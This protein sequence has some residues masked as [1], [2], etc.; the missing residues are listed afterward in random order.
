MSSFRLPL[1]GHDNKYKLAV[2]PNGL[3]ALFIHSP[4]AEHFCISIAVRAGSLLDPPYL[5]GLAHLCEHM[6]FTG[7]KEYPKTG[8]FQSAVFEAG[9]DANAFTTGL[10]TN[11]FMEVPNESREKYDLVDQ[12][13]SFFRKPLFKKDAL[14]LEI[15]AIEEEHTLYSSSEQKILYHAMKLLCNKQHSFSRFFTGN[16]HTLQT[17]TG[18]SD[19]QIIGELSDF[20]HQNYILSNINIIIKSSDPIEIMEKKVNFDFISRPKRQKDNTNNSAF[21]GQSG[22]NCVFVSSNTHC[23]IRLFIPINF[24]TSKSKLDLYIRIWTILLGDEAPGTAGKYLIKTSSLASNITCQCQ[25]VDHDEKLLIVDIKPTPSGYSKLKVIVRVIV[26]YINFI[27]NQNPSKL[28]EYLSE[29][30]LQEATT[31]KFKEFCD[32]TTDEVCGLAETLSLKYNHI[33]TKNLIRGYDDW[34]DIMPGTD[35]ISRTENF[36]LYSKNFLKLDDLKVVLVGKIIPELDAVSVG[37]CKT[38]THTDF[39]FEYEILNVQ[40]KTFLHPLEVT[41]RQVA[42]TELSINSDSNQAEPLSKSFSMQPSLLSDQT[43]IEFWHNSSTNSDYKDRISVHI[44]FPH[45]DRTTESAVMFDIL[46]NHLGNSLRHDLYV[47]EGF[48]V[49]WS[50]C[51][52]LNRENSLTIHGFGFQGKSCTAI[53]I[54]IERLVLVIQEQA[55][56]SNT[57]LRKAR[58]QVRHLYKQFNT[59]SGL[60]Q[61]LSISWCLLEQGIYTLKERLEVLEE[62]DIR[63]FA[64]FC[65]QLKNCPI[66]VKLLYSGPEDGRV[67]ANIENTLK[68]LMKDLPAPKLMRPQDSLYLDKGVVNFIVP[69]PDAT[70]TTM[71]YV[72]F[73]DKKN[74]LALEMSYM[75]AILLAKEAEH[76]LREVKRLG[77][78]VDVSP[79]INSTSVGLRLTIISTTHTSSCLEHHIV[80]YIH[81]WAT[82]FIVLPFHKILELKEKFIESY[83]DSPKDSKM[84]DPPS[85]PVFRAPSTQGSAKISEE[86]NTKIHLHNFGKIVTNNYLF[87][88]KLGEEYVSKRRVQNLDAQILIDFIKEKVLEPSILTIQSWSLRQCKTTLPRKGWLRKTLSRKSSAVTCQLFKNT[89]TIRTILDFNNLKNA[90]HLNDLYSLYMD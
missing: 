84:T 6:L 27:L 76:Y 10:F 20:F 1:T 90:N 52:N 87:G 55:G 24:Q 81:D 22:S 68:P 58:T 74:N 43:N 31:Y 4:T 45:L 77:Y 28:A 2:Y 59:V 39:D 71:V 62:V 42:A 33:R 70:A 7:S 49:E 12:L 83:I 54:I 79:Q 61:V 64:K 65:S 34:Q 13:L 11:Y 48:G 41:F 30:A 25:P 67:L 86:R 19:K 47:W 29:K 37:K 18:K 32:I 89:N 35:W 9:G 26:A 53:S 36:I 23:C 75:I 66:N 56:I 80:S 72:D 38:Q 88:G 3:K 16:I 8:Q 57:D 17:N 82:S 50:V 85:C 51:P 78:F 73:G 69:S 60:K 14:W 46:S 40:K 15:I 21:S 63:D 5:C 44:T